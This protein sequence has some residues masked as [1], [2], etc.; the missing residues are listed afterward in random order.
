P[1]TRTS[2]RPV[3]L[4]LAVTPTFCRQFLMPKLEL[5]RN[6]YP[7]V[8]L[9]LQVSIPLLDVTGEHADLEVRY[10][11]GGYTDCEHRPIS[12]EEVTQA[13]SPSFLNE[14]GP[15]N[16]FETSSEIDSAR[17]IRSP[18]EPWS[19]WFA[20]CGLKQTEP[21]VGAQFN[22]LGLVYDAA[23]TGFGVALV[24]LKL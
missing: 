17:L 14:F 20:S 19:T 22:D 15:F 4:R 10:G 13:C 3:R 5:F 8:E 23:A 18:L 9:V 24:R 12:E 6:A 1:L 11:G 21:N 7:E 16:A 2:A